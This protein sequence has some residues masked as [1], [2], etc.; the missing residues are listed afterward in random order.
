L[1][2]LD[3]DHPSGA[4]RAWSASQRQYPG[5]MS[6]HPTSAVFRPGDT[7]PREASF[8]VLTCGWCGLSRLVVITFG[9][10]P[11]WHAPETSVLI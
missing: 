4:H 2:P 9:H 5:V 10:S 7:T 11:L 3:P 6:L 8:L 1:R